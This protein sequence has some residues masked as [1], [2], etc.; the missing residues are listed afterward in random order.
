MQGVAT[1][2]FIKSTKE[3]CL[4]HPD[5]ASVKTSETQKMNFFTAV[6]NALATALISDEK[7]V[8]FGE[9]VAFGGVF[10]CTIGLAERFGQDRVFNMPLTEQG[11]VG[12][13]IGMAAVGHTPIAEIQFADYVFP[14]FDQ[15]VNEA[16]KYRY[17]SGNEFN[18]AGLTIRMPCNA[19][20]HGGLYHSQSP[21]AY[22]AHT[23]GLKIVYP[24]SPIQAKGLLLA[25]IKDPN[26]V[27]V[28]EPKI[29]Y[30]SAVE[31]VP[32]DE[33]VLPIGKAE[34]LKEGNDL[35]VVAW[36]A[37]IYTVEL[38][39]AEIEKKI[40]GLS[41]EIIDLRSVL[42]W[43]RDAI[44][45]S[46]NKTGRLLIAHEAP[47][48]GG[49]GG[50]IAAA[51]Q[52]RC[53]LK[54]QA[55]ISRVCGWD[56]PFPLVFERFYA[57]GMRM[58]SPDP[59]APTPNSSGEGRSH[60]TS[61]MW[62]HKFN[63]QLS[64]LAAD[65]VFDEKGKSEKTMNDSFVQVCL[66]FASNSHLRDE[67]SSH[68]GRV[69]VGKVLEDLDALAGYISFLHCSGAEKPLSVVTASV[70]RMELLTDIPTDTDICLSGHVSYVGKSSMEVTIKMTSILPN[71]NI[72]EEMM[73]SIDFFR[74]PLPA[75]KVSKTILLIAKF[76]MVAIDLATYRPSAA[77]QLKLCTPEEQEIHAMGERHKLRKQ[78]AA[79]ASLSVQAP[80]SAEMTFVHG[81]YIEY[82][83][84]LDTNGNPDPL[85]PKPDHIIWMKDT[86][87]SNLILTFPEDRNV[88]NK[89]FGGHLMRLGFELGYATGAVF[90][91]RPLQFL[92][93]DDITF[94]R[95]VDV[96]SL[97]DLSAQVVF[98]KEDKMV[99]KVTAHILLIG[100]DRFLSNEFWI[101]FAAVGM[102]PGQ[103]EWMRVLPRSYDECMLYLEGKRRMEGTN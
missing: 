98:S 100:Q 47:Q 33:Y 39:V 49:F 86:K 50:E 72:S 63:K 26:P 3:A 48:T 64:R 21:E 66:P 27:L 25:A 88:H 67:Y 57:P 97:L 6:N 78:A 69:R 99:V 82:M 80:D 4:S 65:G 42:P 17:R 35:T 60:L 34:V 14:A 91:K 71:S 89:I 73:D 40:P 92:S 29:L 22:F 76:T 46:V 95:P 18:V 68:F 103:T 56:T 43:D 2:K 41:I 62:V 75:E 11:I 32:V 55:P 12:F 36:G 9:D 10:R 96:G 87:Q 101:T 84:Y 74:K 59:A 51:I 90:S 19:V 38:A 54:L 23:P 28:M 77:P 79:K 93:L 70:D 37:Q 53:F 30:R 5:L 58:S 44:E 1:S 52:E 61:K 20:G 83:Q 94:R 13:A 102:V 24:R 81:L 8:I 7:A 45:K 31:Q 16:A 85:K 15:I